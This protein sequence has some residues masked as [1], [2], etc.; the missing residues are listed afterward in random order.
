VIPTFNHYDL[1]HTLLYDIYQKCSPSLSIIK[2]VIVVDD[3][4]TDE[5][6][7]NG[8]RWWK[9]NGMLPVRHI[10]M[11]ENS[12]FLKASN[13]GLKKAT[14]DMIC[15]ISNDV[16][17]KGDIVGQILSS[18]T[19]DVV[20]FGGRLLDWDTGWNTFDGHT[21]PYLEGWLLAACKTMWEYVGY[22]DE[23]FAPSDMEDVDIST[24]VLSKGLYLQPLPDHM[25]HHMGGQSI[26]YGSEREAIT[27]A[28]KEKF[29]LKWMT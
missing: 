26:H 3:C 13:A 15:L 4:S 19:P 5:D 10:R 1:L 2:E 29:R 20:M 11:S 27:I 17:I 9:E 16:R 25:T 24:T 22:F 12:M 7:R 21:F 28:N 23:R 14:G 18:D 6:Y 8:L